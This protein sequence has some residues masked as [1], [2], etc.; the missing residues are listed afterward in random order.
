V[1][2]PPRCLL[3]RTGLNDRDR[4]FCSHCTD[5]VAVER[6]KQQCPRCAA[7][8]W[9]A[10]NDLANCNDCRALS[11]RTAGL[12][13]VGAYR[14]TV[15]HLLR[16]YKFHGRLE[17]AGILGAYLSEVVKNA[18]WLHRVEAVSAVPTHWRRRFMKRSEY[19]ADVFARYVAAAT[20]LPRVALL[21]RLRQGRHQIGLPYTARY[22]NVRGA[23][24]VR[25]GVELNKARILLIDDVRTSGAT[26]DECARVLRKAGAA[27]VYA[28][29]VARVTHAYAGSPELVSA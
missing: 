9:D 21:R 17:L 16:S 25:R 27:E 29:V 10:G 19:P 12:V 24:A 23:F 6:G 22:T 15:G 28:A 11:L 8:V 18:K 14:G 4:R 13:R 20:G 1:A 2:F 26:L 3:C 5:L 7:E